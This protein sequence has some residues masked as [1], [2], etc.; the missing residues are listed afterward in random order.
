MQ[1]T[2]VK[3]GIRH[4]TSHTYTEHWEKY[5][6]SNFIIKLGIWKW[7]VLWV[8]CYPVNTENTYKRK[9]QFGETVSL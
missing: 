1:L 2:N 9:T 8:V 4:V 6:K 3:V 7:H 5:T